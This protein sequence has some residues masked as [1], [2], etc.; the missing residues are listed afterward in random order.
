MA[1][2]QVPLKPDSLQASVATKVGI[3]TARPLRSAHQPTRRNSPTRR[4]SPT[5]RLSSSGVC[6]RTT[7]LENG[8][9]HG[10]RPGP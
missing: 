10:F 3:A 5:H 1:V 6:A 7:V 4:I 2:S 9:S 8:L